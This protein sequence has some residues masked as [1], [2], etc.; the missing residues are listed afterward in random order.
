MVSK[1]HLDVIQRERYRL[2]RL[3]PLLGRQLALP[4]R[5]TMPPH[6]RHIGVPL[7]L[8][9]FIHIPLFFL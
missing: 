7:L 2:Q 6:R 9:E 4:H 5:N 8:R 1:H 3:F